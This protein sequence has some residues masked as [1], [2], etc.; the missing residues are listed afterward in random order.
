MTPKILVVFGTRPEAIKLCPLALELQRRSHQFAVRVCVTAQHRA[1]L[2]AVL[3]AF[4][5][6]PEHDLGVMRA[7][8]SLAGLTARIVEGLDAV[9]EAERPDMVVVQGD[10]TTTFA[11]ALAAFY[12]RIPVGHVEAGLRTGDMA[13]PFPEDLNRVLTTRLSALH[14]APTARAERQLHA[15]GIAPDRVFVTGNTGIDAVLHVK[16][17]L[18]DGLWPGYDGPIPSDGKHLVVMTAHRRESFGDGFERICEG[19][20]R[21]AARGDVEVVYPMHPNPNVRAVVERELRG[22]EGIHL[23]EPLDY[24]P[25]VDLLRGADIAL[26]DSGGIQEEAPS[27]GL[28]VLVMREKTERQEAVESGAAQLVGTDPDRIYAEA[29]RLLDLAKTGRRKESVHG[30]FGKGDSSARIADLI[31]SYLNNLRRD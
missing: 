9:I 10:T 20:R 6:T 28:P 22:V 27:L 4:N 23:I 17:G 3:A 1:L 19:V 7:N 31:H 15:E 30:T 5:V 18:E 24:I 13:H 25:F 11:A 26:T 21:V 16:R 2:D 29:S 8:Q 14:F 12:R